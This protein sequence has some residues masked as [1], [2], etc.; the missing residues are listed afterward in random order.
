MTE[1]FVLDAS[2]A[3]VWIFPDTE[4]RRRYAA[5]VLDLIRGQDPRVVVPDLFEYE[6]AQFITRRH[7]D[8][9]ARFGAAKLAAFLADMQTFTWETHHLPVDHKRLVELAVEFH[10]QAK[11][12][13]YFVV[14]KD[15]DLPLATLDGGLRTACEAF[16]VRLL[17]FT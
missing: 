3:I 9:A 11:D 1:A 4:P 7:R 16:G 17:T 8:K 13:P 12:V 2:V 6:F 15:N 5:N 10:L 14:A